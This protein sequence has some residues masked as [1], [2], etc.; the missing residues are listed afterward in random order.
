MERY[1]SGV[2]ETV[3]FTELPVVE[4][5]DFRDLY[6]NDAEGLL[7]F[8]IHGGWYSSMEFMRVS[9]PSYDGALADSAFTDIRIRF[10]E[11]GDGVAWERRLSK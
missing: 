5:E 6:G 4:Q 8:N 2:A 9:D 7:Y 10:I 3:H 1:D 11:D